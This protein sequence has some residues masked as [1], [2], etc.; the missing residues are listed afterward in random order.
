MIMPAEL[1]R[2]EA[3]EYRSRQHGPGPVLRLGAP[4]LRWLF[5]LV[6][7]LTALGVALGLGIRVDQTATGPARLDP[8]AQ[9]FVAALPADA[10]AGVHDGSPLRLEVRGP[11][12]RRSLPAEVRHVAPAEEADVERAGLAPFPQAAVLVTGVVGT[13][14]D[15]GD[16]AAGRAVLDLGSQQAFS[17]L[18]HGFEGTPQGGQ[19]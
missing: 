13:G 14:G 1:F 12:G 15:A 11:A 8:H 16:H 3:L 10:G 17:V 7:G 4:W 9:T 2:R 19:G 18:L 5:W 6:L